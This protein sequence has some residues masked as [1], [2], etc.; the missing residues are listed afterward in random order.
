MKRYHAG[1]PA[2]AI[3]L[4]NDIKLIIR[5]LQDM[6]LEAGLEAIPCVYPVKPN[7]ITLV[8]YIVGGI[9]G[10]ESI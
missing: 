8:I 7:L 5:D 9:I 3:G 1:W 6:V 4:I 10:P 2:I